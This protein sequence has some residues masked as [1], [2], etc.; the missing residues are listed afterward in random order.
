MR[1]RMGAGY[2]EEVVAGHTSLRKF[3]RDDPD[4]HLHRTL[5]RELTGEDCLASRPHTCITSKRVGNVMCV[6]RLCGVRER[7][8]GW[9]W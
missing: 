1:N 2:S 8:R 6:V 4:N 3:G 9:E 7:M 5:T